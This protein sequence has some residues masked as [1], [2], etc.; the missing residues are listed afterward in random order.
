MLTQYLT[1]CT[2][3]TISYVKNL[4]GFRQ[5]FLVIPFEWNEQLTDLVVQIKL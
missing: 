4:D 5:F 3:S 1:K 2:S